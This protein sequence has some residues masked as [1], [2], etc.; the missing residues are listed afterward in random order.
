MYSEAGI[1]IAYGNKALVSSKINLSWSEADKRI[2]E[3]LIQGNF[4]SKEEFAKVSNYELE[5]IA[6]KLFFT[7]REILEEVPE[8]FNKSSLG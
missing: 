8:Y 1:D 2:K 6:D 7:Y 4:L 5:K 3:L